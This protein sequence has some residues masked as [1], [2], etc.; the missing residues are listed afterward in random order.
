MFAASGN[1]KK[2]KIFMRARTV[3]YFQ[4]VKPI[5]PV[6]HWEEHLADSFMHYSKVVPVNT[7]FDFNVDHN[8][9]SKPMRSLFNLL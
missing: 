5:W 7:N 9:K 8:S 6:C 2:T 3:F 1:F 4:A